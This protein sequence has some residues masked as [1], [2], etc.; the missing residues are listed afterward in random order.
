MAE[1]EKRGL[2]ERIFGKA[3]DAKAAA[4]PYSQYRLLNSWESTFTPYSGNAYAESTVRA[5]IDGFAR[6][7]AV[8]SPRHVREVAGIIT[9]V[10]DREFNQLLQYQPNPYTGAYE[11]YYRLATQFKLYNN[12]FIYPQWSPLTGRLDSLWVIN[13]NTVEMLDYQGEPYV[14]FAF[15]DGKKA[16]RPYTEIIHLKSHINTNDFFGSSNAPIN[17]I[18]ETADTFNQSMAKFAQL[19]AKIRGVLEFTGASKDANLSSLRDKFITQNLDIDGEGSGIIVTDQRYKYTPVDDKSTPIPESQLTYIRNEIYNYFGT[20]EKIIQNKETTDEADAYYESD[21]KPFYVQ[22][23]QGLTNGLFW[24][25]ERGFGNRIIVESNRLQ[26]ES[27]PNKI[28]AVGLLN[29]MGAIT[30]DQALNIFNLPPIGGEA[31]ARRT[32][33]LNYIDANKADEYQLGAKKEEPNAD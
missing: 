11:F 4:V 32:Q 22:L 28:S 13:A 20:N 10:T 1:R 6:R 33:S 17:S 8:I 3:A 27:V 9:D 15:Y 16:A 21:V 24:G 19:I 26:Y 25:K 5:A 18:L 7:A 23:A 29:S 14:R 12:A 31:G 2:F 30:L